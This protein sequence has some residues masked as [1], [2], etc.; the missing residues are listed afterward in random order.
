[1][2]FDQNN[3]TCSVFTGREGALS[4]IGHD[5][6]LEVGK[7]EINMSG[8]EVRGSFDAKSLRVIGAVEG[9]TVD[10]G[11]ISSKD[12]S[13]IESNIVKDVLKAKKFPNI[14]F[15]SDSVEVGDGQITAPGNLTICGSERPF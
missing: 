1:M 15:S 8:T 12:K 2:K 13:K 14:E 3:S 11:E 4:A 10:V 9:K 6:K 5:L 7:F